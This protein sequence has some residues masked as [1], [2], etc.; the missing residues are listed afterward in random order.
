VPDRHVALAVGFLVAA[1]ILGGGGTPNPATEVW[2]ELLAALVALAWVWLPRPGRALLPRDRLLWLRA[3]LV[4]L[5]P[6][7][8]LVPLPPSLWTALPGR[9]VELAALRLVGA[10]DSWQPVTTSPMRTL[11]SLLSL[12]PPLLVLLMTAAMSARQRRWL[13]ATIAAMA[14]L[15]ALFGAAQ[16]AGGSA[17]VRLY[18]GSQPF[19]VTGFQANRNSE[20]DVLL[21][22]LVAL[23]PLMLALPGKWDDLGG[24][25]R[26]RALLAAGLVLVLATVLTASRMGIALIPV[27][28]LGG[29]LV[30]AQGAG[31]GS[32]RAL[33]GGALLLLA[34]GLVL[35]QSNARLQAVAARFGLTRDGREELWTDSLYVIAQ[36]WPFGSGMGTFVPSFIAA[37][38]LEA[39]NAS[40]PNRAHNDYL[41]LAIE[42]GAF[43]YAALAA[44]ALVLA[45]MAARAWRTRPDDRPQV[46]FGLAVLLLIALHSLVDYPLRSMAP[47]CFAAVGAGL[48]AAPL[49]RNRRHS[50]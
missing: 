42:A 5:L 17:A 45:T 36:F 6:L 22:G 26:G 7:A 20:A 40:V 48:L 37:E 25:V 16:L 38:P 47:A 43:G 8:Q 29:A 34:A 41:E 50:A 14:L 21:I 2:L 35:L 49:G 12:G 18:P 24:R 32:L 15:S 19:V 1:T 10:G 27:A 31:R 23:A 11:A 28:L 33:A 30:L 4:V 3:A 44:V 46:L 9:E 39:V 13:I